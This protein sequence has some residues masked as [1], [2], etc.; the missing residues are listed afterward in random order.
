MSLNVVAPDDHISAFNGGLR[1]D[2][3]SIFACQFKSAQLL[4]IR[5][6]T[7]KSPFY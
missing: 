7:L 6:T 1:W 3:D 2:E 4:S 5:C